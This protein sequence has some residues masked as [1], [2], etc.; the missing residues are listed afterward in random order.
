MKFGSRKYGNQRTNF[1]GYSFDSKLETSVYQQLLLMEK[2]GE[3]KD[4]V[5]KPNIFLTEAMIRMI[6]DFKAFH[7]KEGIEFYHEAKGFQDRVWGLK[8]KLYKVYGPGPYV[9]WKG[10]YKRPFI[11]DTIY[12]KK[13]SG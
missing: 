3:I 9:I 4:I 1:S 10:N 7:I 12:P 5:V 8:L 2:A 11:D 13:R 6:P